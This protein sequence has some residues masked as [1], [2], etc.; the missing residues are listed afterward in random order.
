MAYGAL[1]LCFIAVIRKS[2]FVFD[3]K[4]AYVGS[5]IFLIVANS[6][7]AFLIYF[8]LLNRIGAERAV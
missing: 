4:F 7:I 5:L 8:P 2:P 6:V 1:L 3:T